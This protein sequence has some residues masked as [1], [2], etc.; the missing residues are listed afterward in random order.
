[1]YAPCVNNHDLDP[2]GNSKTEHYLTQVYALYYQRVRE[3]RFRRWITERAARR[4]KLLTKKAIGK[5]V[6]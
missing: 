3:L 1:M 4:S 5:I 2:Q 6:K